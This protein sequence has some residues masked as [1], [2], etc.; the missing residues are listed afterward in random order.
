VK[1]TVQDAGSD[2]WRSGVGAVNGV[3]NTMTAVNNEIKAD[4]KRITA[5]AQAQ[6]EAQAEAKAK[7]QAE[8]QVQ[9]PVQAQVQAQAQA[10]VQVPVQA[11][12][13]YTAYGAIVPKGS[14][15]YVPMTTDFSRFGR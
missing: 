2:I 14:A 12:D 5:P 11:Q 3:K 10:Q 8:A 4:W 9:A 15:D 1:N 7:A 13:F 6:A